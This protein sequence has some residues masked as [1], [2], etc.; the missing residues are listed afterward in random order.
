VTTTIK[1][2]NESPD[3]SVQVV[4]VFRGPFGPEGEIVEQDVEHFAK[5]ILLPGESTTSHIWGEV[6]LRVDELPIV[7]PTQE[8]TPEFVAPFSAATR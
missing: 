5:A 3:R 8:K 2:L 4:Q 1:I 6:S 7:Q